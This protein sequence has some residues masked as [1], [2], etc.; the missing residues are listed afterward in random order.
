[1]TLGRYAILVL[2]VALATLG[3]AWPLALGRLDAPA[4]SAVL[5]GSG[6]AVANTLA[7]HALVVWSSARASTNAFLGAVL[8]GMVG[9][10]AVMLL[11]VAAAVIAL[12]LPK[13]PLAFSLL[14]YFVVFLIM[15]L[16]ILHRRTTPPARTAR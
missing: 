8:G 1:L 10:M 5:F 6:L 13:L 16:S 11:A 9:R 3:L 4:R 14:S 7:A 2:G 15:E 12:G